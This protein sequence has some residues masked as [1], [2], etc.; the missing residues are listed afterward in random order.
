M[1]GSSSRASLYTDPDELLPEAD[2]GKLPFD[3]FMLVQNTL[4]LENGRGA[5]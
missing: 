2:Y 4:G 5:R 3:I 1:A